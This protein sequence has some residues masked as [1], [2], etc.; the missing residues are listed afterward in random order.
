MILKKKRVIGHQVEY[1]GDARLD[2]AGDVATLS[3]V[4]SK[5]EILVGSRLIRANDAPFMNFVPHVPET[6]VSGRVIS[7]YG[8]VAEAGPLTTVVINR[9]SDHGIDVGSVL[10]NYK[11]GRLIRKEN[12]NEP[13]RYT[14]IEKNGNLFIYRVFPMFSYGLVLDSLRA[15]NVGDEVKAP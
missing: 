15:V 14:P 3:L 13:N 6:P 4:S 2:V 9:G 10:F 8:G 1:L 7:S 5:E 12:R 11:A